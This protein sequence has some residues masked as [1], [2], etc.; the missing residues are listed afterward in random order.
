MAER[1]RHAIDFGKV[2]HVLGNRFRSQMNSF[3]DE[4]IVK[5]LYHLVCNIKD[6]VTLRPDVCDAMCGDCLPHI[7]S[8]GV[9]EALSSFWQLQSE[10]L[11]IHQDVQ[12]TAKSQEAI[13]F[14]CDLGRLQTV[15]RLNDV[16]YQSRYSQEFR[17]HA[18]DPD[19]VISGSHTVSIEDPVK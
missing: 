14:C 12:A 1:F 16:P 5:V 2:L 7:F 3:D 15:V 4:S 9:A 13:A 10:T 8:V 17:H 11:G 18:A 6:P 19:V